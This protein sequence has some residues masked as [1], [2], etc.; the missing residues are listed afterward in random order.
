M[1][2]P[3]SVPTERKPNTIH[4]RAVMTPSYAIPSALYPRGSG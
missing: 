3:A 2:Q 1:T 4:T